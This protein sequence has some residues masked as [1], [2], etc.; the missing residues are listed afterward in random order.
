MIT[1]RLFRAIVGGLFLSAL[2]V[3]C[4]ST[5]VPVDDN[6]TAA[7]YFQHAQDAADSGNYAVAIADYQIFQKKFPD[8]TYHQA[9]AAYEIAFLHHKM[10]DDKKAVELFKQLLDRYSGG[11]ALPPAPK[12]LAQKVLANIE[13]AAAKGS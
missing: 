6:L 4:A 8:D 1:S 3:G 10:G 12:V 11:E 13:G 5:G 9:W 2:L 7:E